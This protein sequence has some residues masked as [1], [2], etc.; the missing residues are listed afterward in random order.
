MKVGIDIRSLTAAPYSGVGRQAL[1]LYNT[2][3][4]RPDTEAMPFTAAP[5]THQHRTWAACPPYP[6]QPEAWQQPAERYSFERRFLPDAISALA[7]DVYVA[8]ANMGLPWGLSDVRRRRT[9]WVLQ[10]HD[11]FQIT[12]RYRHESAWRDFVNTWSDRFSIRHSLNLADAIWTPSNYTAQAVADL[13]PA[14]SKRIRVL[15]AAVPFEPWQRLQQEVFAPQ[16]YWL[17]VGT[18]EPRKNIAWFIEAWQKAR[19]QWPDLIPL[20]VL[21]GHPRDVPVVPQDVRFVHGINDGQL[22]NWYIQAD[23]LWHPSHAEGFG[24]PVIEAAACGTPVATAQ[25][26]ALDEI[27][28]PG[29]MRFNPKDTAALAQLMFQAATQLP[30]HAESPE[31]LRRWALRYDLPRYAERVDELI[32]ELS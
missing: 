31:A 29:A 19:A 13:F 21:I 18:H 4:L 25:G 23:R 15:P 26:S 20:L 3:R 5:L 30:G 11:V 2:V 1:A 7:I 16:R 9:K 27:T 17:L 6:S 28:P 22:R 14:A 12:R 32:K 10:M 8:T 24:L